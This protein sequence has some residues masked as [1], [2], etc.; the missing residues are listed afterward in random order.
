MNLLNLY[1]DLDPTERFVVETFEVQNYNPVRPQLTIIDG[2]AYQG[3]FSFYC[4]PF[5]KKIYAFEPD[6]R[7]FNRMNDLINQHGLGDIIKHYPIALAGTNGYRY[8]HNSGYGG[9]VMLGETVTQPGG[10]VRVET[11]TLAK[12]FEDEKIK[13]VDILKLDMEEA[14]EEVLKIPEFP[15]LSKRIKMIIGEHLRTSE[16]LLESL[17][18]KKETY[19]E[20]SVFTK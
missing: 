11:I 6:P 19:K 7:P 10:S 2:G 20:N 14:E 12:L 8:L 9:S 4:L 13:Q 15:E 18:Y 5:A 17:G 3:E 16:G 1:K